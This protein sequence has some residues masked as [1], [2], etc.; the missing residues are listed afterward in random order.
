MKAYEKR[1]RTRT[2]IKPF[3][4]N[5][6]NTPLINIRYQTPVHKETKRKTMSCSDITEL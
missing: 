3:N 2:I 4:G 5:R 6:N 1:K